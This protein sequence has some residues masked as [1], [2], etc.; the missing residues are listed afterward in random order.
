MRENNDRVSWKV[1][2]GVDIWSVWEKSIWLKACKSQVRMV[3]SVDVDV[4][5]SQYNVIWVEYVNVKSV[6]TKQLKNSELSQLRFER[7]K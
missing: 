3:E 2:S 7:E 6:D 1:W 5:K 4:V